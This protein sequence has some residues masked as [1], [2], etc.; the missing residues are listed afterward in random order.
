M[1]Q[2]SPIPTAGRSLNEKKFWALNW[3]RFLLALY[4]VFF[5]TFRNNYSEITGSWIE[6]FLGLGN[7]ATSVFFVLSGFLLT[8]AY[9]TRKNG[10]PVDK[11]NFFISRFAT[12]YPLHLVGLLVAAIPVCAAVYS[13]GGVK[14]PID[15]FGTAERM[16]GKL[17]LLVALGT[18]LFLMNAWNPYYLSF[19]FASWSLSALAFY[20]LLFPAAARHIYKLKSPIVALLVL[21]LLFTIPGIIADLM[22]RKDLLTEGLLHRNPIIRLPLFLA[23]M[24]LCVM[25][26]RE[27]L[28]SAKLRAALMAVFL[29]T[30]VI[31]VSAQFAERKFHVVQNGLYL[32]AS[33]AIVWWCVYAKQAGPVVQHWGDRLGAASLPLFLLHAPLH[34]IFVKVEKFVV[35]LGSVSS[36][37]LHAIIEA[38]RN[39]EPTMAFYPVYLAILLVICVVL[40]ERFVVPLQKIIRKSFG[41]SSAQRDFAE[42]NAAV[43]KSA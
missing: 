21:G 34:A 30:F 7:M 24:V 16:L 14:V 32:P 22:E 23:G 25:L 2:T 6:A 42:K 19:N 8:H 27:S 13:N 29:I 31:G 36:W 26:A 9:V 5:H 11:R 43:K 12:L 18:N 20:Y 37:N 28:D 3:L 40:Q 33:I 41:T 39:V 10:A 17:E 1:S 15:A 35:G 4:L 38:G